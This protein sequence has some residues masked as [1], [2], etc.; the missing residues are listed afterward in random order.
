MNNGV[1][2]LGDRLRVDL[3]QVVT[4]DAIDGECV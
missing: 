1:S 2:R 3:D 4:L